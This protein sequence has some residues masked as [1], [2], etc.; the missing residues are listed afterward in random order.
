MVC[1]ILNERVV[2]MIEKEKNEKRIARRHKTC[3]L[4]TPR[5]LV[6]H[7]LDKLPGE[8]FTENRDFLDTSA[9]D[10]HIILVVWLRKI[11]A[12]HSH[13]DA[14]RT[15]WATEM[16]QDNVNEMKQSVIDAIASYWKKKYDKA[17]EEDRIT[18]CVAIDAAWRKEIVCA[19]EIMRHNFVCT[20]IE[21]W[22]YENWRPKREV[23]SVEQ[24]F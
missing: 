9:G 24:L 14:L 12:G 18:D 21:D 13:L 6:E 7:M 22:D 16:M 5:P 15:C 11:K 10:G 8:M 17:R 23:A 19:T 4:F 20:K 3:E 2:V 1:C